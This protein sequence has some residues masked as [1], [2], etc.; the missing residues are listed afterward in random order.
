MVHQLSMTCETTFCLPKG[1]Q[2]SVTVRPHYGGLSEPQQDVQRTNA[3]VSFINSN[4]L[5]ED[6]DLAARAIPKARG[7]KRVER[8]RAFIVEAKIGLR[9]GRKRRKKRQLSSSSAVLSLALLRQREEG[10]LYW[11]L[12]LFLVSVRYLAAAGRT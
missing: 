8:R 1:Q 4:L 6:F 10:V 12:K 5:K 9:S 7:A 2:Q 3:A 11:H